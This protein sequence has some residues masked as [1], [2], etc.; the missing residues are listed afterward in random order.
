MSTLL[1][2]TTLLLNRPIK[3]IDWLFTS[4]SRGLSNHVENLK[5]INGQGNLNGAGSNVNNRIQG[6]EGNNTL[7]GLAGNDLI[8]GF[9]GNDI[10]IGGAGADAL[11]GGAGQDIFRFNAIGDRADRILDFASGDAVDIGP[12]LD[13]LSY[14]GNNPVGAGYVRF[15]LG[16]GST[17][18][19]ID[20]DGGGGFNRCAP[21]QNIA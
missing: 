21:G 17:Y 15:A 12:L 19:Q 1:M 4:Q 8:E 3:G 5:L 20:A 16:S 18:V 11:A 10:L 9:D 7:Y 13:T 6:N 14:S 2:R